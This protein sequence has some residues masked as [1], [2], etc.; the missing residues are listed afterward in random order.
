MVVIP[1]EKELENY[2]EEESA[3]RANIKILFKKVRSIPLNM[4]LFHTTVCCFF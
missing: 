3:R 1:T 4:R 2:E